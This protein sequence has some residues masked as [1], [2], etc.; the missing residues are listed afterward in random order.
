MRLI[1]CACGEAPTIPGAL[2][3]DLPQHP[4]QKELRV[5]TDIAR[6]VLPEDPT[7]SLDEIQAN[8]SVSHLGAPACAPQQPDE[9]VR[10]I[11]SG[12][13]RALGLVLTRLMRSDVMWVEV[14]YAP[15]DP[16]SPAALV[17]GAGDVA[18]AVEG[19]VRP[20][21]SVRTDFGEVVAGSA[22]LFTGDGSAPFTGEI[23]VDSE[24]LAGAGEYG[25]RLVPTADAPGIV[26]VPYVS[27][28]VPT[29]RFLRRQPVGR[30][31][32]SRVFAGRALQAG[33]QEIAVR[34]D[35]VAR[36]RPMQRVTFYR[37]LRD[38]QSVREP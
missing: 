19:T 30:T 8:P 22:E 15:V 35:G 9:P 17:W 25:A 27:P 1:H 4:S 34:I 18:L 20:M 16:H 32:A 2:R 5:L 36:P 24:V 11:V 6:E 13:D 28:L 14:G 38:I 37:H 23:V 12:D 3:L 33:G 7:P 31:D 21:P 26:A 29:R 10:A